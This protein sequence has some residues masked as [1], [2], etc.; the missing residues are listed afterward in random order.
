MI[1]NLSKLP[2]KLKVV[3]YFIFI[4]LIISK[5]KIDMYKL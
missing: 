1:Q 4:S 3:E 5:V 2:L